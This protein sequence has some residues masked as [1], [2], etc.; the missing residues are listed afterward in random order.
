MALGPVPLIGDD[1]TFKN[2]FTIRAE[3]CPNRRGVEEVVNY[4]MGRVLT[5]DDLLATIDAGEIGAVWASAGY[6]EDWIDDGTAERLAAVQCLVVQDLF[7]SPLWERATYQLPGAA[8][9][10]RDGS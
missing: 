1:E 7:A 5:L 9:A 8:F 6:K 10:E 4:F 2:G 3:K